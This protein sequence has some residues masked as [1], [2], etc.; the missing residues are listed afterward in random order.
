MLM[1][2][3]FTVCQALGLSKQIYPD[4]LST[5][6]SGDEPHFI[7]EGSKVIGQSYLTEEFR[8]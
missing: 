8:R 5:V 6:V 2:L 1:F 3:E 7:G 4:S